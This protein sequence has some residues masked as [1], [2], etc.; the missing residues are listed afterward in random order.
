MDPVLV[1]AYRILDLDRD[2]PCRSVDCDPP[3]DS[4]CASSVWK[5]Y[6]AATPVSDDKKDNKGN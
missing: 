3:G 2:F 4:P 1:G 6:Q 5:S